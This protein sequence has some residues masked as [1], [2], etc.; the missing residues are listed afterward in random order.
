MGYGTIFCELEFLVDKFK[1][2]WDELPTKLKVSQ[3]VYNELQRQ[4]SIIFLNDMAIYVIG[5]HFDITIVE[6]MNVME[7]EK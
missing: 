3:D 2:V 4:K 5:C 6:G 7:V 1:E